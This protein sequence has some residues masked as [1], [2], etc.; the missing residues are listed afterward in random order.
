MTFNT[1]SVRYKICIYESSLPS[2]LVLYIDCDLTYQTQKSAFNATFRSRLID[3]RNLKINTHLQIQNPA[4]SPLITRQLHTPPTTL[5]GQPSPL[6]ASIRY[7]WPHSRR[8][9]HNNTATPRSAKV[10][11]RARRKNRARKDRKGWTI[12]IRRTERRAKRRNK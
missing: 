12:T 11:T 2:T 8:K 6:N 10:R 1:T 9:Q 5:H 7:F 4:Q 3:N